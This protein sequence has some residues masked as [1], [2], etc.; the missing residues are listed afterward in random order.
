MPP[1]VLDKKAT[2]P[3]IYPM[4]VV[5]MSTVPAFFF[6]SLPPSLC[7]NKKQ[8]R[9]SIHRL[10]SLF[11]HILALALCG[12]K[13]WSWVFRSR[14]IY[15]S[16]VV[17]RYNSRELPPSKVDLCTEFSLWGHREER[18]CSR[19]YGNVRWKKKHLLSAHGPLDN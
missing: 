8:P 2:W 13:L 3:T 1:F 18:I 14:A 7:Q 12:N 16:E 17:R 15:T 4:T 9:N 10:G 5:A 19:C 11:T 6:C